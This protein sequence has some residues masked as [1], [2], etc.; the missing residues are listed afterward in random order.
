MAESNETRKVTFE[1]PI[2]MVKRREDNARR[3]TRLALLNPRVEEL[4]ASAKTSLQRLRKALKEVKA[5][6]TVG[7]RAI[8][9]WNE[10]TTFKDFGRLPFEIREKIWELAIP[11]RLITFAHP[12]SNW[13]VTMDLKILQNPRNAPFSHNGIKP[14]YEALGLL[15]ACYESRLIATR[16]LH[17]TN[18]VRHPLQPD[19]PTSM[20]AQFRRTAPGSSSVLRRPTHHDPFNLDA[21]AALM[22]LRDTP[23]GRSFQDPTI[24]HLLMVRHLVVEIDQH[25]PRLRERIKAAW[26][27]MCS[28]VSPATPSSSA[29][30]IIRSR[31]HARDRYQLGHFLNLETVTFVF[32]PYSRRRAAQNL[33]ARVLGPRAY[34]VYSADETKPYYAQLRE[35][36]GKKGPMVT[37]A[38][39]TSMLPFLLG[40]FGVHPTARLRV[41]KVVDP[42]EWK[43]D[44]KDIARRI[45]GILGL[46]VIRVPAFVLLSPFISG[47]VAW[48]RCFNV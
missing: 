19:D 12:T 25:H 45:L 46:V 27:R 22:P 34:V 2:I 44:A 42:D 8:I 18:N 17:Q 33:P 40:G 6:I 5:E 15:R 23:R 11:N 9:Y 32:R 20:P 37:T 28:A 39:V 10:T 36:Y 47:T 41:G 4:R 13:T 31:V 35:L 38:D 1:E 30:A 3:Q 26:A 21:D 7:G 16:H 14:A 48:E 43:E 24:R 29:N